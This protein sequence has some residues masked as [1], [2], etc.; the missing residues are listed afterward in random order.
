MKN[1]QL[2][3]AL[4]MFDEIMADF[5]MKVKSAAMWRDRSVASEK[6]EGFPALCPALTHAA[7]FLFSQFLINSLHPWYLALEGEVLH[8]QS[9]L[10]V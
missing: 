9:N 7:V 3:T 6:K 4:F 5:V 10:C 1:E 2:D 8:N